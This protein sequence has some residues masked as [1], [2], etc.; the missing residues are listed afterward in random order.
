M[1]S[2]PSFLRNRP[3]NTSI[4]FEFA[5]EI[6]F[7]EMLDD[8]A[9]R[10]DAPG[11]VHEIGEQAI[12]VARELDRQIVDRDAPGAGVEPDRADRQIAGGVAGG[13]AQ[14]SAQARQHFLHVERAWR[15]N[16]RRR[17]QC[18]GPCRSIDRGRS[19][20]RPAS[21]VRL[22]AML[23]GQKSRRAWAGRCRARR[24]R[25]VRCRR[26]T[27][28]PRRQTPDRPRSPQ[29]RAQPTPDG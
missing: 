13:A 15:H 28:L 3:M 14:Q 16:R 7:V 1:M 11:V 23:R 21:C 9:A 8:L 26:E 5:V 19:G 24:R 12:L 18:P 25:R 6:L 22:C 2:T 27:S 10:D 17:R 29:P 20:S 4:V